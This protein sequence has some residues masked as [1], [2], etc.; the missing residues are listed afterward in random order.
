MRFDFETSGFDKC[1]YD[2]SAFISYFWAALSMSF[3]AGERFFINAV[4]AV[5]HRIDDPELLEEIAEFV[6][7]EGHHSFQHQKFNRMIGKLGFDVARYEGRCARAL[8]WAADNLRPMQKLAVT[9]ALEHF[10][11]TLSRAWLND[12]ELARGVDPNVLALWTWHFAEEIEHKATCF[13]VYKR[14]R[15]PERTRIRAMRRAWLLILAITF[16]NL[17]SM[18]R[19]DG[20]LLDIRDHARGL[21]Y[22]FGPRG[23]LTRMAPSLLTYCRSDF[24]PWQANDAHAILDWQKENAHY[25]KSMRKVPRALGSEAA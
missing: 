18:L 3:P 6:R 5:E 7:Q 1:W 24:H 4:S 16:Q 22:L 8:Q 17:L 13:D 10:T 2:G 19:E 14:L 20:R 15:G 9:V 12:P 11:A 25:I 21:W 23:L